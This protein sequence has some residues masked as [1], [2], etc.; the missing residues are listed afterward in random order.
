MEIHRLWF[1]NGTLIVLG[2]LFEEPLRNLAEKLH[3]NTKCFSWHLFQILR[4]LVLVALGKSSPERQ[5]SV[6]PF[7]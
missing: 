3:I 1:Y 6:F 4:T 7:P 2:I 5:V